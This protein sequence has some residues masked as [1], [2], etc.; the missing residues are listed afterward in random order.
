MGECLTA[1]WRAPIVDAPSGRCDD[2]VERYFRRAQ[3]DRV[4]VILKARELARILTAIGR[5]DRW[6]PPVRPARVNHNNFCLLDLAWE[7][8]FVRLCSSFPF[9][10]VLSQPA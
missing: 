2:F 10:P 1:T 7:R 3:P 6:H 4:I 9:R 5:D 8:M